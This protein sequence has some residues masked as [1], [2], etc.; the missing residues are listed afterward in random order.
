LY[1]T[2]DAARSFSHLVKNIHYGDDVV[3]HVA[4]KWD[5][6]SFVARAIRSITQVDDVFKST[7]LMQ[8]TT[9]VFCA[10]CQDV[11]AFDAR[12]LPLLFL[13]DKNSTNNAQK[14]IHMGIALP[15]LAYFRLLAGATGENLHNV[16]SLDLAQVGTVT[17]TPGL[18][19]VADWFSITPLNEVGL[20]RFPGTEPPEFGSRRYVIA[21]A[22][23]PL[24]P[25]LRV[26]AFR[27]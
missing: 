23:L 26:A 20:T 14:T 12:Q 3:E 22:F 10:Y 1:E 15:N 11:P 25:I 4:R 5:C 6:S 17:D 8:I 9:G 7:S 16:V 21:P 24:D 18:H 13:Y 2:F 27:G 19:V